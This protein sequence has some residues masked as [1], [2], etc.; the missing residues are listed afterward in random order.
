MF[1]SDRDIKKRLE[2]GDLVIDP[3]DDPETQIQPA[4]IDLTL[5]NSFFWH[6]SKVR[7]MGGAML[8]LDAPDLETHIQQYSDW[9]HLSEEAGRLLPKE[10]MLRPREF[11]LATTKERVKIPPDLIGQLEGRSSLGRLGLLVHI[12]AGL[13]DP[14]FE[15]QI[16][17][18]IY[19][20]SEFQIVLRPGM[21]ISQLTLMRLSSPAERPYG[22]ARGSKY[23][24]QTGAT[25]SQ[26]ARDA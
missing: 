12:T 14:G 13:I 5:G 1:L 7:M 16:T 15:G 6:G 26:I 21:R 9:E 20:V 22:P 18:E 10:V 17:L 2:R 19:N 3:L 4:S 24:G 8:R 11:C 25:P 23:Q